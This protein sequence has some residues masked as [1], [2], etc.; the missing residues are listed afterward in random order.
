MTRTS[1]SGAD[2][3]Q[4]GSRELSQKGGPTDDRRMI[5]GNKGTTKPQN[6]DGRA[7]HGNIGASQLSAVLKRNVFF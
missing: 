6:N 3:R 5:C 1:S 7:R 4:L 2:L